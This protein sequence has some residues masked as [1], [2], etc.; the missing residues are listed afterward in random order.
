MGSFRFDG[1]ASL[2]GAT[3]LQTRVGRQRAVVSRLTFS[4]ND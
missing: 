3:T 4:S 2:Q 1:D